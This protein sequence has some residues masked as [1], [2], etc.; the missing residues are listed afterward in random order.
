LRLSP[1]GSWDVTA[2]GYV[3]IQGTDYLAARGRKLITVTAGQTTNEYINITA[4]N[5][6]EEGVFSYD[7]RLSLD[8]ESLSKA[9]LVFESLDGEYR[10]EIDLKEEGAEKRTLAVKPGFYLLKVQLENG[11]QVTGK[12]EVV[13]VY[14]NMETK[15][16]IYL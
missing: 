11:Y 7:I 4:D 9:L 3:I 15:G 6:G 14:T 2:E 13:H 5:T 16:G 1:S 12:T 10:T 8:I